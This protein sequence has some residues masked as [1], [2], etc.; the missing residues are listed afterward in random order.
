MVKDDMVKDDD[1]VGTRGT[2]KEQRERFPCV[3]NGLLAPRETIESRFGDG[4]N[5][6]RE[7]DDDDDV[8][9]VK[10][11][12]SGLRQ[13]SKLSFASDSLRWRGATAGACRS[14]RRCQA[15]QIARATRSEGEWEANP[16]PFRRGGL[17]LCVRGRA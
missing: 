5:G 9:I 4:G 6:D 14:T 15:P 8:S 2:D 7:G 11:L 13:Q 16:P 1:P 12:T 3:G 10:V 17:G